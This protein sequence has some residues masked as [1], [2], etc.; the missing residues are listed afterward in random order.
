M[1][2]IT[3]AA[4]LSGD[5]QSEFG[6]IPPSFLPLQNKRLFHHQF[7]FI[8][9]SSEPVFLTVPKSFEMDAF[10]T[11]YISASGVTLIRVPDNLTLSD[12]VLF[13]IQG[14]NKPSEKVMILHG[15]TLFET[16]P[17]KVDSI[18]IAHAKDNYNWGNVG[19]DANHDTSEV[20]AGL[21]FFSDQALLTNCL[22][23]NPKDFIAAVELYAVQQ[24]VDLIF[25]DKWMDFG[26]ANTYFRSKAAKT[27]ERVFNNLA[28][29]AYT[30][31][32]YSDDRIKMQAEASWFKNIPARL[33]KYTPNL[34]AVHEGEKLGYELD[35]LYLNT[36]AE[37]Y[38]F[39]QNDPFVWNNIFRSCELF[40]QGCLIVTGEN[41][42]VDLKQDYRQS[43]LNK[44]K[45]RLNVFSKQ[46]GI[47]T[48]EGWLFNQNQVPSLMEIAEDTAT[49]IN[50]AGRVGYVHGDFCFSNILFDFRKQMIKVIDPR[51]IDFEK[52]ITTYGDLRYDIAKLSHSVVGLYD[53]IIAGR[54]SLEI[55][56]EKRSIALDIYSNSTVL[57]IQ[58]E[59]L[60]R[61][62]I[63]IEVGAKQNFAIMIHL[64]LS[65]LP[66]HAD[67]EKRQFALMANVF[68]LYQNFLML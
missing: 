39:G 3:S 46:T 62:F 28:I 50:E 27:T 55:N 23:S 2:I 65:M 6:A 56:L 43:L 67:N 35:Y 38:V 20:Y 12:S 60:Q 44:T 19:I 25:A 51:G 41:N 32:K 53:Y 15:D 45:E 49:W 10:D 30:V 24:P 22:K 13:T 9:Q 8:Q 68:R 63:G 37:L 54:F 18:Y 26:H 33:K 16:Y 34:I 17:S 1:Q 59:F 21:F 57:A 5:L 66:L 31:N 52:N 29:D 64:F 7:S 48:S 58:A 11:N 42:P 40:M 14:I 4:Y 36:L 61:N 47:S